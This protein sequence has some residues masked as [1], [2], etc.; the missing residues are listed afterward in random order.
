MTNIQLSLTSNTDV[1]IS[2]DYGLLDN[3]DFIQGLV[4]K[5]KR[6][7][8][9]T[10]EPVRKLYASKVEAALAGHVELQVY[11]VKEGE[12]A[13]SLTEVASLLDA[14]LTHGVERA[15]TII[16]IGGGVVGD[17]AAFVASICLR[18]LPLIH[19]PTTLLAQVD[20]SVGGKTGV[21]H[22]TGKNLIG[23]FYQPKHIVIDPS[24][25]SSLSKR[26]CKSG[27]AEVIKYGVI[28][29]L[30]LFNRLK[31]HKDEL[32]RFDFDAHQ[33][34][35]KAV[36]SSSVQDKVSVVQA[37]EKESNLRAILNFGH[38]I[39]HAI[40][41]FFDYGFYKHGECVAMGMC[42]ATH[43]AEQKQL[44]DTE[45]AQSIYALIKDYDYDDIALK[46]VALNDL[47]PYLKRDKK[48]KSG[49]L[50]FILPLAI[51]QVKA[52]A[53]VSERDIKHSLDFIKHFFKEA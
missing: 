7:F 51:G 2:I 23:S 42:A 27:F 40:E 34:I 35:W 24:V 8:I 6:A 33:D 14:L 9:I 12:E 28:R 41:A 21:N 48:V 43:I 32:K 1:S 13:K 15:D 37:D 29:N 47:L 20:S 38:S 26:E 25:L 50:H 53:N 39:G 3:A 36:I 19:I 22:D 44:I 46:P 18:G 49:A 31:A 52:Y 16:A 17:L 45:Q 4:G 11:S 10:Q 30:A 5:S